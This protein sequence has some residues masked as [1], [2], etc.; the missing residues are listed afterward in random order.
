MAPD[1]HPT[2]LQR[3]PDM[4]TTIRS[5]TVRDQGKVVHMGQDLQLLLGDNNNRRGNTLQPQLELTRLHLLAREEHLPMGWMLALPEE[6]P[7]LF[8]T[9][10]RRQIPFHS[11]LLQD[12]HRKDHHL[13]VE[14]HQSRLAMAGEARLALML[15][16]SARK[17][18]FLEEE[19]LEA[20]GVHMDRAHMLLLT[21][22]QNQ[23][24]APWMTVACQDV[25][26]H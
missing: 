6:E 16:S 19:D 26:L 23:D 13:M 14:V 4:R 12:H 17:M 11:I 21:M 8:P 10:I 5:L 15:L 1:V 24:L 7:L 18:D 9:S 22:F 3:H 20:G 25:G 2:P